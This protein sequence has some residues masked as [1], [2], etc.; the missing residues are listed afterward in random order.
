MVSRSE[1]PFPVS[2]ALPAG[3]PQFPESGSKRRDDKDC[4]GNEDSCSGDAGHQI[5]LA[6]LWKQKCRRKQAQYGD[7]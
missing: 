4:Q 5:G 2:V 1:F 6:S 7:L 3:N